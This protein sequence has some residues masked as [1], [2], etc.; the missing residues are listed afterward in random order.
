MV[1]PLSGEDIRLHGSSIVPSALA[2]RGYGR[3]NPYVSGGVVLKEGP[4]LTARIELPDD[5]E[6]IQSRV[7]MPVN[8]S[9]ED[10]TDGAETRVTHVFRPS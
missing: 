3:K 7:G 6:E 1:E 2:S 4:S 8:A 5:V 10:E 9:F